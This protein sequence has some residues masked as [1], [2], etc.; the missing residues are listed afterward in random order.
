MSPV[1][2]S[3]W[4]GVFLPE[5]N[6]QP[7][8]HVAAFLE[9]H[10][11]SGYVLADP[12]SGDQ[13]RVP[14]DLARVIQLAVRTL[15]RNRAVDMSS[16]PLTLTVSMAAP[17]LNARDD[18]VEEMLDNGTLPSVEM[19]YGGGRGIPLAD[20]IAYREQV[21]AEFEEALHDYNPA[22]DEPLSEEQIRERKRE[23]RRGMA[24][25]RAR[26][27]AEESRPDETS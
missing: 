12:D 3:P 15:G 14:P 8:Q 16:F 4:D 21:N 9:R 26:Q 7:I 11:E 19:P 20:L 2:G 6:R 22:W 5:E 1:T 10:G 25:E 27:A 23:I 24:E 18:Q 13:V 17:L